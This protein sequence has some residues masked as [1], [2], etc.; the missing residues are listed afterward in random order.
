MSRTFLLAATT[1]AG[2]VALAGAAFAQASTI[3]I[4]PRPYYGATIT[5]EQGV[6]VWRPL[7][8]TKYVII[9][10]DN[11]TPLNLSLADINHHSTNTNTFNGTAGAVDGVPVLGSSGFIGGP[12]GLLPSRPVGSQ[13][14]RFNRSSGVPAIVTGRRGGGI[15]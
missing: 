10:P 6:R 7:P 4:E 14:R 11:R 3:R 15:R 1:L 8:T 2:T 13:P 12:R 5:L 9:N